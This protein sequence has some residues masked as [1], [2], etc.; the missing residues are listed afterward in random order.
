MNNVQ[1]LRNI[2]GETMRKV[3]SGE[4]TP[5]QARA[6][7]QVGAVVCDTVKAEIEL[8]IATD[9]DFKGTGFID[10]M[11]NRVTHKAIRGIN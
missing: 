10:V 1:D 11:P 6:V 3:V 2:L 7:A 5:D 9:G 8:A 4:M